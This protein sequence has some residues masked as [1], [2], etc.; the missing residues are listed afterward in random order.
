MA[1]SKIMQKL[2]KNHAKQMKK[3]KP[4]ARN[5]TNVKPMPRPATVKKNL[6]TAVA[7]MK[8]TQKKINN[9]RAARIVKLVN[10]KK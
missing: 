4:A 7:K 10:T 8:A 6:N 5:N 2:R 9:N 1:P 3:L